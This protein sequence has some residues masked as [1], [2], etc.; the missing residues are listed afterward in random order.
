LDSG[1]PACG[2][3]GLSVDRVETRLRLL[4]AESDASYVP[5]PFAQCFVVPFAS[6]LIGLEEVA[7]VDMNGASHLADR[8][9]DGMDDVAAQGR[10]VADSKRAGARRFD[11]RFLSA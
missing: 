4:E 5:R 6:R 11:R 3:P 2:A 10:D 7:A 8:I 9:Q 1:A